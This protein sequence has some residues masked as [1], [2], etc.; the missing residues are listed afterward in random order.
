MK[1]VIQRVSEAHV[2]VEGQE[3]ARIGKGLLV[4]AGAE[5]GDASERVRYLAKKV[6]QLRIFEDEN[7]KMNLNIQSAGGE[8]L[9]VSQFT[10]A[11]DLDKGNR[12]SFDSAEKPERAVQLIDELTNELKQAGLR[13]KEGKFGAHMDVGLVNDGPV[14][15]LLE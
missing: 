7:G 5:K 13:V 15:F 4:L 2:R 12:P 8:V 9:M 6:A 3:I 1:L 10:L 11:A 14:T